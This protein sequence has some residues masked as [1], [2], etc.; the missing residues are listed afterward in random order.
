MRFPLRVKKKT[1]QQQQQEQQQQPHKAREASLPHTC[2]EDGFPHS[3][4]KKYLLCGSKETITFLGKIYVSKRSFLPTQSGTFLP[5]FQHSHLQ[6]HF[7][8][9]LTASPSFITSGED[10]F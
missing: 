9:Y 7:K 8:S 4:F 6:N 10:S 1:Q 5:T 3:F 2:K